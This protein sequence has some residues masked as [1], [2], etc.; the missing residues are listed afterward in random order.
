MNSL[1]SPHVHNARKM[2]PANWRT[3]Y[4]L[5]FAALNHSLTRKLPATLLRAFTVAVSNAV[6]AHAKLYGLTKDLPD[7]EVASLAERLRER[8]LAAAADHSAARTS[9]SRKRYQQYV[10]KTATEAR[11]AALRTA[12]QRARRAAQGMQSPALLMA[13]QASADARDAV[14]RRNVRTVDDAE[15]LAASLAAQAAKLGED[16]LT[17]DEYF[18]DRMVELRRLV[19]TLGALRAERDACRVA[20]ALD[21]EGLFRQMGKQYDAA[22]RVLGELRAVQP[23]VTDA[24]AGAWQVPKDAEVGADLVLPTSLGALTFDDE[25][26]AGSGKEKALLDAFANASRAD[27]E[28]RYTRNDVQSACRYSAKVVADVESRMAL[29]LAAE[30]N[31]KAS[32]GASPFHSSAAGGGSWADATAEQTAPRDVALMLAS[33]MHQG[34]AALRQ[35][36]DTLARLSDGVSRVSIGGDGAAPLPLPPDTLGRQVLQHHGHKLLSGR[37]DPQDWAQLRTWSFEEMLS[38]RTVR[39]GREEGT[40][41]P[42]ALR[43]P[44][45]DEDGDEDEDEEVDYGIEQEDEDNAHLMLLLAESTALEVGDEETDAG[46][47]EDGVGRDKAV[48]GGSDKGG[49]EAASPARTLPRGAG[50]GSPVARRG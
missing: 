9:A 8:R 49:A 21:G 7:D 44:D 23:D 36:R 29:A 20:R 2:G 13:L 39:R 26:F 14:A 37:L 42:G 47:A 24:V 35:L 19:A 4:A 50:A 6:D 5:T 45:D 22:K 1:L 3:H 28:V 40:G 30:P 10:T 34:L 15:K 12:V 31:L 46:M 32:A 16:S 25:R 11:A 41:G 43:V 27:E 38:S 18:A 48:P 33:R 17:P